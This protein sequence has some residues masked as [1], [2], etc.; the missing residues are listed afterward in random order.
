M[1]NRGTITIARSAYLNTHLAHGVSITDM[2]VMAANVLKAGHN[3]YISHEIASLLVDVRFVTSRLSIGRKSFYLINDLLD[4]AQDQVDYPRRSDRER[5]VAARN[6]E[7]IN[8]L[9][10]F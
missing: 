1:T 8:I 4:E 2:Q 7:I 3:V 6:Q 5:A 10:E 9:L